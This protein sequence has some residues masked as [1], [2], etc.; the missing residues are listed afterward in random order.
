MKYKTNPKSREHKS[1]VLNLYEHIFALKNLYRQGWLKYWNVDENK[2]ESVG[3]HIFSMSV[4]SY[5]FAKEYRP[6]LDAD[7][8]LRIALFHDIPEAI[9]GDIPARDK[10]PDEEKRI[11]EEDA[12]EKI[13]RGLKSS[14]HLMDL[15]N[16]YVNCESK[17]A[18]FVKQIDKLEFMIQGYFYHNHG[19]GKMDFNLFE[20]YANQWIK[21]PQLK[22]VLEEIKNP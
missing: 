2:C 22:E 6:D 12:A 1:R 7:K 5:I 8:V 16:E 9:I 11:L 15:H 10:F 21:D 4:I 14:E 17:E 3:D 18:I 20:K 13:Y 19:I